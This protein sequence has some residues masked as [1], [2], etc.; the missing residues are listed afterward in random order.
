[1]REFAE[2]T[3]SEMA[4]KLDM[5]VPGMK[6]RLGRLPSMSAAVKDCIHAD[7]LLV[8]QSGEAVVRQDRARCH[9]A[10][11][12]HDRIRLGI[13]SLRICRST[14]G[15]FARAMAAIDSSTSMA[16]A[17]HSVRDICVRARF[18]AKLPKTI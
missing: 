4:Q 16:S 17:R 14:S 1:M 7:L 5:Q 9:R 6:S 2:L 10:R 11:R 12:V 8:A 13:H 3:I 15:S 18:S